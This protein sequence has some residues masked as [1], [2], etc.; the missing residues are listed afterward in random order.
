MQKQK[1][2]MALAIW[3]MAQFHKPCPILLCFLEQAFWAFRAH[4]L[5]LRL[6]FR[7]F[8]TGFRTQ[9]LDICPTEAKS[10]FL[11]KDWAIC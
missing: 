1:L 5:A 6:Q 2:V 9:L 4:L 10:N 3:D 8:G 7:H 11:G